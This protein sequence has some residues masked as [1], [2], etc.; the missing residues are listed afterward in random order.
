MN[1][2]RILSVDP[3]S[4][5]LGLALIAIDEQ[6]Q[7]EIE[8]TLELDASR[9]L[10]VNSYFADIELKH[11][12]R[13]ARI[14]AIRD[15]FLRELELI[16]PDHVLCESPFIHIRSHAYASLIETLQTLHQSVFDFDPNLGFETVAPMSAKSAIDATG[17]KGGDKDWIRAQLIDYLSSD[18][19]VTIN[20]TLDLNVVSEHEIDAIVIGYHFYRLHYG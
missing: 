20:D 12:R 4:D 11:G 9:V 7:C 8:G 6:G 3:G 18:P 17:K 16:Q 14:Q 5:K 2:Y 15:L 13:F 1:T 19:N 10:L